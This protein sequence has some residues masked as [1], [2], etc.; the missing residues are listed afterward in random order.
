MASKIDTCGT[1]FKRFFALQP[2][3]NVVESALA[4]L[5][6]VFELFEL[7][8]EVVMIRGLNQQYSFLKFLG[9]TRRLASFYSWAS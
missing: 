4:G 3:R 1:R 8:L 6:V 7:A 2:G 5:L 9:G